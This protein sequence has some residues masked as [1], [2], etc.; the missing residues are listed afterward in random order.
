MKR[1]TSKPVTSPLLVNEF[2]L[3]KATIELNLVIY[4]MDQ[5]RENK[6]VEDMDLVRQAIELDFIIERLAA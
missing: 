2:L 5:M 6:Q 3:M 1:F 4:R